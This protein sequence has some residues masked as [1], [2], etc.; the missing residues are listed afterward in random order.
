MT[1]AKRLCMKLTATSIRQ[2]PQQQVLQQQQQEANQHRQAQA[3]MNLGCTAW[4]VISVHVLRTLAP[5]KIS[6]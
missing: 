5:A 1:W 4:R 2:Q 6:K 3:S